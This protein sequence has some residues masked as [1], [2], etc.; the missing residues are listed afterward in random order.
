MSSR[1]HGPMFSVPNSV[2]KPVIDYEK[3]RQLIDISG[4]KDQENC[5]STEDAHQKFMENYSSIF[6]QPEP[7]KGIPIHSINRR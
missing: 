7:K 3:L 4:L 1:P 5:E 2:K 6:V